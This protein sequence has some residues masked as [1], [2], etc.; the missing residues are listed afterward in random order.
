M[1]RWLKSRGVGVGE[2]RTFSV[3]P[4]LRLYV[5]GDVHGRADLLA[6]AA[7]RIERD[8]VS[9]P[10]VETATIF[11]GDYVDRGPASRDVLARLSSGEFPT[12]IVPLRGNHE[13]MLEQFLLYPE[14]GASWRQNGG[15]ETLHSYGVDL[16]D[17]RAGRYQDVAEGFRK[18]LP[19]AHLD[20]VQETRL[21]LEVGDYYFCHAGVRPGVSLASQSEE[22]LLWI[23]EPFLSSL[24][25]FEKIVV[26]GHTPVIEPE[27][28]PNRIN[29][30]TGAYITGRLTCL[31]LE[32]DCR[33]FLSP[34]A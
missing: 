2:Q 22:D 30:D 25:P 26:H 23:R 34:A 28:R 13:L 1:L 9:Q 21:S 12:E 8:L 4:G 16:G 20:F 14:T 27:I 7:A 32:E 15:L 19:P 3:P 29:L 33:R 24:D 5:I 18:A 31:V 11:L 10:K 17:L 6:E